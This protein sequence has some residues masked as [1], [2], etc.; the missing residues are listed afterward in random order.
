M[1]NTASEKPTTQAAVDRTGLLVTGRWE[2][3]CHETSR[4][5]EK[6]MAQMT[7]VWRV[8]LNYW[9]AR[10]GIFPY[11]YISDL[12]KLNDTCLPPRQ[13]LYNS[14]KYENVSDE[15]YLHVQKVW[16]AFNI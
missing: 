2:R 11:E 7:C 8:F 4:N 9:R 16:R 6:L 15:D 1:E 3:A 14:L 5:F 13:E 10:T 12:S